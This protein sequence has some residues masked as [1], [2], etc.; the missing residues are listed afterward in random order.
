MTS[1]N[2]RDA[3]PITAPDGST[4]HEFLNPRNSVL[5]NQSL[6][7]ATL[8]P[9]QSTSEHLH[10]RAEEIYFIL[11][12]RGRMKIEETLFEVSEGDAIPIPPGQ[13]HR[14]W[15][16]MGRASWCFCAVARQLMR[17]KIRF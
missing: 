13:K 10:P 6:A 4:I 12:G 17:M 8:A 7:Q 3:L 2:R 14:I 11:R 15:N 5:Q 1:R 16:V 9:G